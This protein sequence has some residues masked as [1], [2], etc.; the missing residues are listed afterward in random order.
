MKALWLNE[1]SVLL[2]RG[3]WKTKILC[4]ILLPITG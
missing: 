1:P 4:G 2:E 3:A